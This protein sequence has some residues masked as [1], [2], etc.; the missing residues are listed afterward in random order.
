MDLRERSDGAVP[1]PTTGRRHPWERSRARFFGRLVVELA[2]AR[3]P[4]DPIRRLLDVGAGDDWLGRSFVPL[5]RAHGDPAATV[6]CWDV[7]YGADDLAAPVPDGLT[8][9]ATRPEGSFDLI[10]ALDVIEHV[11]DEDQFLDE[12][13]VGRLA[14]GGHAIISAP[15]YPS[16]YGDH[17]RMLGHFRRYRPTLLRAV[18]ERHLDIVEHGTLFTSLLVPRALQVG[19]E[20]IGR[21]GD[22]PGVGGWSG[23]PALTRVIEAVLDVDAT[24]SRR[25]HRANVRVPGLSVWVVARGRVR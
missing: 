11:A 24:V 9:T 25:L 15:A 12:Q 10:T 7:H 18:V 21:H 1:D 8:R 19:L 4:A 22:E 3:P 6:T 2:T 5:V 17:D 20:R 16:L 13:V 23:G 14:A